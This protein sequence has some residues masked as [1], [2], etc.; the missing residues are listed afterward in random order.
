MFRI[1]SRRIKQSLIVGIQGELDHHTA[2]QM[3]DKLDELIEDPIIKNLIIDIK[4]MGFMDS[5]GIG[6]LIGRYKLITSRGGQVGIINI[7][8]NIKK[9]FRVSGLQ[10]IFKTYD[11][12]E[13]ALE[14]M[15]GV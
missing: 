2:E 13:D 5:S 7:N 4:D 8:P 3:R 11:S 9:I 10:K 6:V 12:L 1:T 14:K 15:Q